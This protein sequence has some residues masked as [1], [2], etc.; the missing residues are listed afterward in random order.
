MRTL[1]T[2]G[3]VVVVVANLSFAFS[4]SARSTTKHAGKGVKAPRSN[5]AETVHQRW[6]YTGPQVKYNRPLL[7][8]TIVDIDGDGNDEV[9]GLERDDAQCSLVFLSSEGK[10]IRRVPIKDKIYSIAAAR[11]GKN[12]IVVL[13][14]NPWGDAVFCFDGN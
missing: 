5:F 7:D 8:A 14:W 3:L 10:L 6:K 11:N 1:V 2:L 4:Q 12:E 9:I 13:G